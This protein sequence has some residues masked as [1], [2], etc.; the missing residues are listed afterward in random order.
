P[1]E[2]PPAPP[3]AGSVRGSELGRVARRVAQVGRKGGA[4]LGRH[5]GEVLFQVLEHALTLGGGVVGEGL[6]HV[7]A[8]ARHVIVLSHLSWPPF[9][10]PPCHRA[11]GPAPASWNATS[12]PT[13]RASPGRGR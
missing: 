7:R 12:W 9:S 3:G 10:W 6:A 5:L 4:E 8:V 2:E 1:W 11:A 13:P